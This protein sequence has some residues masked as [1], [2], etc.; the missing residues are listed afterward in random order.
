MS[1]TQISVERLF[2]ALHII[3]SDKQA[4]IKGDLVKTILLNKLLKDEKH[5]T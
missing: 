2:F 3:H 5:Q 1:P 4:S